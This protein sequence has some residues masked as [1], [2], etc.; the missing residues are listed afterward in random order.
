MSTQD[1][2]NVK[3][4]AVKTDF[5]G[6]Q[7]LVK[8]IFND[9]EFNEQLDS[10]YKT[11]LSSANSMNWGRLLP[12]IVYHISGYLDLV[13]KKAI[14]LGD[15]IDIAVPT[16]NFGNILAAFYA[17]KMGLPIRKLI[18]ASNENNVL[19][20]FLTTGIYDI[21]N[22]ELVKTPS[23]SMDILVASNIER[24][25]YTITDNPEQVSN[26]MMQLKTNGK[27]EVDKTTKAVLKQEFYASWASNKDCL[28]NIKE[29]FDEANYLMD[30]HTSIAH[31][32]A[33]KY[34]KETNSDLPMII[35]STAHWAKFAGAIYQA[36]FPGYELPEDEFR[37]IDILSCSNS[38]IQIPES[39]KTL[40]NKKQ[41]HKL[42]IDESLGEARKMITEFLG[43][44]K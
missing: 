6:V 9:R 35:C 14:G 25:L 33:Q 23:P 28:L 29:I 38:K 39:L 19:S 36:L 37:I 5:D 41:I 8:K 2:S 13:N 24:L 43:L 26:W 4:C 27:F 15:Q 31:F 16:G 42:V 20:E 7:R 18:C 17:K 30:P 44:K 34:L 21:K 1:G 10:D 32:V 40:K 3:V 22:R 11:L 12:Q